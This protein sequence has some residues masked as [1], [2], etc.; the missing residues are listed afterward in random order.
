MDENVSRMQQKRQ[1]PN[2]NDEFQIYEVIFPVLAHSTG[3]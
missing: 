2:T 1:V 3:L